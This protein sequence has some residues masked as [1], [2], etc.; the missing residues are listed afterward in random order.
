LTITF[1]RASM[2]SPDGRCKAFDARANGYVRGEGA[3]VVVLK[4]LA[5]AAED[6]DH[7]HCV[8]RSTVVNQ[9]G[10]TTTITVPNVHAQVAMLREACRRAGVEPGRVGYVEAHGTGTPVGDPIEAEAIGTVFGSRQAERGPCLIG[11]I[12]TNIG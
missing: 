1:S 2:L 12:K 3:G 9:D 8:I 11:S 7:I 6:G 4:P 10:R 5:R